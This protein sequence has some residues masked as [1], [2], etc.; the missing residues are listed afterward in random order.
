MLWISV[1]CTA[2]TLTK[3]RASHLSARFSIA[4]AGIIL[5]RDYEKEPSRNYPIWVRIGG[6]NARYTAVTNLMERHS[7][8]SHLWEQDDTPR[9]ILVQL[10]GA[11]PFG[12]PYQINSANSGP[13]GGYGLGGG[14]GPGGRFPVRPDPVTLAALAKATGGQ[15]F[16]A[17]SAAKV[18]SVYKQ[19]G[20]SIAKKSSRREVSSWF[21][22]LAAVF[23][24]GSLGAARATG[25]RLP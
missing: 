14:F 3:T 5:P 18:Q 25:E 7:E 1:H 10:D 17:K 16:Q 19:L 4:R 20:A 23:L 15:A 9:F 8:L 11:G 13:Y 6:L 12:D 2:V 21:V 22:G 24:L